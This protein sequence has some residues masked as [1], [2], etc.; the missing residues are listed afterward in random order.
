MIL[1][2]RLY[3][4]SGGEGGAFWR[5]TWFSGGNR[6]RISRR[7]QS[8]KGDYREMTGIEGSWVISCLQVIADEGGGGSYECYRAL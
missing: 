2:A 3:L 5:I 6:G 4:S 1:G 8:I 7:Q